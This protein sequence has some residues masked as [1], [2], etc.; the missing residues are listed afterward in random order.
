M[1][2]ARGNIP[3]A[4][5]V[6][7]PQFQCEMRETIEH[8]LLVDDEDDYHFITRIVLKKAGF[9]GKFECFYSADEAM[10][11]LRTDST[12]PDLILLD[13]NMPGYTGFDMLRTMEAEGLLPNGTSLVVMCSSS[14]RP[15]DIAVARRS[16]CVDDY[17]EKS[18]DVEKFEHLGHLFRLKRA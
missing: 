12:K 4:C 15:M 11:R 3:P 2:Y 10:A 16:P 1:R 8:V 5:P 18:F 17:M 9:N 7:T 6:R 14:N 13:I